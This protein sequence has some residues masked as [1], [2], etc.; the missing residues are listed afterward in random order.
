MQDFFEIAR[1]DFLATFEGAWMFPL[2]M[3]ASALI[4]WREKDWV[5]KLL[6]GALPLLFLLLYWCPLTGMVF[7][8]LLGENVYW[9]IL[10]L[11]LLAAT[12]PYS[13]CLLAGSLRG[14]A[15]YGVLAAGLLAIGLCGTPL[16]ASTE[17]QASTN[18]YKIP[19][20]VVAVCDLLPGNIHALVSNRLM[21]YIRMY[22]PTITLEYGRNILVYNGREANG[23]QAELYLA[24]QSEEIDVSFVAPLAKSEGCTFLVFSNSRT[25]DGDWE[26]YG[27]REYGRT[28]EFTIFADTDYEEGQDTRKW[29]E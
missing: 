21:P 7:M 11:I 3:A 16:L 29:E 20:N 18:V 17:F 5:R 9:R 12:V 27:Y 22:D 4:L 28:E 1:T 25:Y 2:L 24:T 19:Q 23:P 15:R 6:L 13:F 14:Y 26:D 10:W 8:K